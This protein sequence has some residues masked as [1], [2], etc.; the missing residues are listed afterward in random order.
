[1]SEYEARRRYIATP[2]LKRTIKRQGRLA[3][4]FA[5]QIGVTQGH[6]SHVL[7]GRRDVGEQH[8]RFIATVLGAD[9]HLLWIVS[10][11]ADIASNEATEAIAS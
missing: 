1:M 5:Q 3:S 7:Y 11:D 10:T 8:A 9:F 2:E 6:F 4:W